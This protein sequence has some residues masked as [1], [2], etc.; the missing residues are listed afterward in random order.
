[1]QLSEYLK[2]TGISVAE[3]ASLV[4]AKSRATIH[5]YIT[6]VASTKR[7]PSPSMM[8]KITFITQG[9]V[10]AND[11]YGQPSKVKNGGNK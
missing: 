7:Y 3:F 6:N 9:K 10:T 4:G 5:R 2:S 8:K 1:M 11:F